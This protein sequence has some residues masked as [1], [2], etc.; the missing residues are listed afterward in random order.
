M[1]RQ[2]EY[3]LFGHLVSGI[4]N[5]RAAVMGRGNTNALFFWR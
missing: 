2:F 5:D 3:Q 4:S 1:T